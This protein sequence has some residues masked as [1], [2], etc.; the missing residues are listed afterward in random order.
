VPHGDMS[1]DHVPP[2]AP[3]PSE[4]E[5]RTTTPEAIENH[6]QDLQPHPFQ[7]HANKL[8]V[9][10]RYAHYPSWFPRHEERLDFVCD[11]DSPSSD[12]RPSLNR[13]AIH[14][15]SHTM[16]NPLAPFPNW[17]I[18]TFMAE[19][20]SGLDSKSEAHATALVKI[21]QDPRYSALDTKGF[22]AHVENM[23]LDKYL[24][25]NMHPFQIGDGWQESTIY[26]RLPVE[27]KAFASEG[28]A[29]SLPIS[30]LFHRRIT[31]IIRTVC[32]SRTAETFH[33]TP[34]TMHWCPDPLDPDTHERVYA[35]T[36]TSDVM[37][38]AQREVDNIPREEGDTKQ[39]IALGLMLASDSAQLTSFGSAS[40][41]PMYL[42]FANQPKDERVRPS[43]HAVHH[44]AYVPSVSY[45]GQLS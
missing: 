15:I 19:Y 26:V 23:R 17:S 36:Y 38:Q 28:N 33:F 34:Y 30:G 1:L 37:I 16:P 21:T 22:N 7:T 39:R 40:V 12:A 45:T 42:M 6:P 13:T 8:G 25:D 41:W 5:D 24:D 31:D 29:P 32:A 27:K 9:F 43:C 2:R 18:A 20:F 4:R 11:T 35:D 44:V 14:E 10:R 3:T